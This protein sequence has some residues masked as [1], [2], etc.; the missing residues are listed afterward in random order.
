LDLLLAFLAG[1]LLGGGAV[2]WLLIAR[3]R[4]ARAARDELADTFKALSSEALASS[5]RAFLDLARRTLEQQQDAARGDLERR[6]QAIGELVAPVKATLE[7]FETQIGGIEKARIEAYSTLS[8]QVRQM[9]ESQGQ[10]RHETANLVKA[11]RAPHTRGRWGELQL[12]RV[13]EMAGMLDHCDFFEQES[14][15]TEEGRLRPDMIVKLPGGKNIVVDAKAPLAAYLEALEAK[16]E[17]ERA[18]KLADHARHVRDHLTKL[19]RKSYWEQFQPSPD[20]VVLFLPGETFYS[21]A[22]E[23]D[24]SLI[25]SGVEN[26]VILATPTTLIA[27]LRAV[28]YGW[29]QEAL[30]DN[31]QRIS[32]LGREL[33]ERL[34]VLADHWSSVGRNLGEAVAAYNKAVG[35][36]ESRVLVSARRFRELQAAPEG[37]EIKDLTAVD[38]MPRTLQPPEE[39]SAPPPERK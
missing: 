12:K 3:E 17:H 32:A 36:L 25:E 5:N 16:D 23:A 7:K 9:A 4:A 21:A 10:L 22:L 2:A 8:E 39:N 37:R 6:Q 18:R 30:N 1:L 13:V 24:P 35:S 38:A 20:F 28:A 31:A 26:R 15:D 11:L 33:Y 27:L 34:A 19:G 14:T 29:K